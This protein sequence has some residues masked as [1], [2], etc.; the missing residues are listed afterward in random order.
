M[1]DNQTVQ[2]LAV[3]VID[4]RRARR[5]KQTAEQAGGDA[6]RP[7][8]RLARHFRLHLFLE[9]QQDG[10]DHNAHAQQDTQH[11][12]HIAAEPLQQQH[13][14]HQ[15]HRTAGQQRAQQ[16]PVGFEAVGAHKSHGLH[17]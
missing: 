15:A 17:Q 6:S 7:L 8:C 2:R 9:Q 10:A 4:Q 16:T 3:E 1:H 5:G 11:A 13:A 14:S 12:E